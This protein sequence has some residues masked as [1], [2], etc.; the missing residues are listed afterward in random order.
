VIHELYRDEFANVAVGIQQYGGGSAEA[1]SSGSIDVSN[2]TVAQKYVLWT[3]DRDAGPNDEPSTEA[4]KFAN[5]LQESRLTCHVFKKREL[6]Y[7]Y[8]AVVHSEAQR[9]PNR[10]QKIA[11]TLGILRGDQRK[12]YK[13]AARDAELDVC[14]PRG[15]HLRSLL[16]EYVRC[17]SQ[18]DE[19][20]IELVEGVLIPW[21]KQILG[22]DDK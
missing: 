22:D 12:K 20:I 5:K 19:E 7:Y 21:K 14:V 17:R 9:E 8:P 3:H 15:Q 13:D 2:I 10:E 18:L 6:E 16:R 1:I 4:S 11:A